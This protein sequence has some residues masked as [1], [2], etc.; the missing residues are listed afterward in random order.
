MHYRPALLRRESGPP[1]RTARGALHKLPVTSLHGLTKYIAIAVGVISLGSAAL[2]FFRDT[3]SVAQRSGPAEGSL[4]V[5]LNTA[6]ATELETLP[7]IG[8]SLAAS[9]V[10][11]RPYG[12][13]DDLLRVQGIGAKKLESLRPFLTTNAD[14][15]PR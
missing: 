5:N 10:A 14:T 9:I 12:S 3:Q 4:R 13:V 1:M 8:P 15:S 11:N 7:G 2:W 6:S